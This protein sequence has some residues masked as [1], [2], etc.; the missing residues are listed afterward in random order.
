MEN[1]S[2]RTW[3]VPGTVLMCTCSQSA[4][5]DLWYCQMCSRAH[6]L[7]RGILLNLYEGKCHARIASDF[8]NVWKFP[9]QTGR[10]HSK[11]RMQKNQSLFQ[12]ITYF[13]LWRHVGNPVPACC[14][15][16]EFF[17]SHRSALQ[18]RSSMHS[19]IIILV[20]AVF[21]RS[22]RWSTSYLHPNSSASTF[23]TRK[24]EPKSDRN[25]L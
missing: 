25:E 6:V 4:R 7:L 2:V 1:L 24:N 10:F 17:W 12:V 16:F 15:K 23:T 11:L 21:L 19:F 3:Y 22:S 8:P 14:L 18:F 13:V 9:F 20:P 5:L